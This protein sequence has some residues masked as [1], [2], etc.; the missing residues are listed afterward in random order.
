LRRNPIGK[1]GLVVTEI[2]F[3]TAPLGGMPDTYGHDV[4]EETARATVRAI[5]DSPVNFIDTARVYGLGRA[6]RR[7]GAVIRERGGLPPGFVLATKLD[8]DMTTGRFDA[9]QARRSFEESL[10][11]L[12]VDGVQLLH[13]HDP[14]YARDIGEIT[15]PGGALDTLF[16]LKDE[17]LAQAVGIAMGRVDMLVPLFT[18]WPVDAILNHNRY[19]LL[20]R[21][22]GQAFELAQ[23]RG[24][25]ILN[26]APFAGGVLAKGS[27]EVRRITYQAADDAR[28]EPVRQIEAACGRHKCPVGAAALQ[29]SMSDARITSTVVGVSRPERVAQVLDWASKPLGD[30]VWQDLKALPFGITDPEAERTFVPG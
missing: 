1:T 12:G 10:E 11:A 17:G 7:I 6:E 8:R 3:G 13:L 16:R 19:T 14:E 20:N 4:S 28:L 26:A 15:G 5:F 24:V 21:S 2:G 27:T 9:A 18:E 30:A 25:A 22:A 29:F 23:A